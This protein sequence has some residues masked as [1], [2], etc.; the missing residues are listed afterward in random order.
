MPPLNSV[1]LLFPGL[2]NISWL[3]FP[4]LGSR[5]SEAGPLWVLRQ[6]WTD[7]K[8]LLKKKRPYWGVRGR[9]HP[10]PSPDLWL[11][12]ASARGESLYKCGGA[13]GASTNTHVWATPYTIRSKPLGVRKAIHSYLFKAHQ[14]VLM[15]GKNHGS[16]LFPTFLY[17]TVIFFSEVIIDI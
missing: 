15:S 7:K 12:A 5:A 1:P 10:E 3:Y 4:H 8:G 6:F 14:V 9:G 11:G 2:L 13:P 16:K 17:H